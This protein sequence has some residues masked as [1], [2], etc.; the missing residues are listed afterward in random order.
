MRF[1][2]LI[3]CCFISFSASAQWWHVN[4]G[5]KKHEVLPLITSL[6]DHSVSRLKLDAKPGA[7]TVQPVTLDQSK[8]SLEANEINVMK[9]AKHNMRFRV[10]KDAS[11]NFNDLATIYLKLHR[12]SEAKWYYLQSNYL[13]RQQNDNKL[14]ILN[15]VG[16]ASTKVSLC[17]NTSARADLVEA[18]DLAKNNKLLISLVQ[19]M[20]KIQLLDQTGTLTSTQDEKY[21][22][23]ST[24]GK[25]TF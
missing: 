19:I 11:Y 14:T 9:E 16:L 1:R 23:T 3:L 8:Y 20:D 5:K 18:R 6:K 12:L 21:A 15:L 7:F 25:K 24:R 2:L 4:L 22:E 13:S 10:Y 17:D